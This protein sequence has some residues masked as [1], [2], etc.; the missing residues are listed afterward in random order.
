MIIM[1]PIFLFFSHLLFCI[2]Y[3]FE[4][5]KFPNPEN[6]LISKHYDQTTKSDFKHGS[7]RTMSNSK[8]IC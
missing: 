4:K 5:R 2:N 1:A 3:K 7:T 8:L 6:E